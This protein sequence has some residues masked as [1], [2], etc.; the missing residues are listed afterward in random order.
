MHDDTP[1]RHWWTRLLRRPGWLIFLAAVLI[2]FGYLGRFGWRYYRTRQLVELIEGSAAEVGFELGEP[3]WLREIVG[4]EWMK[5][6]DIPNRLLCYRRV[7]ASSGG[8]PYMSINMSDEEFLTF[9]VPLD[10]LHG[11]KSIAIFD[12]ALTNRSFE[13]LSQFDDLEELALGSKAFDDDALAHL[14]HARKLRT[15]D[16]SGTAVTDE[17]LRHLQGLKNLESLSLS[18]TD[19]TD[20]G[21]SELQQHLPR[22]DISDD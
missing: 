15:L 12:D 5:P 20:E 4:D 16:L 22:L 2:V 7:M 18:N 3:Q 21:V 17:G 19:V 14:A 10:R 13:A 11:W 1:K 9:V 6:L 8:V